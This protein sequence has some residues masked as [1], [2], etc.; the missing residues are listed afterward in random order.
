MGDTGLRIR[1]IQVKW[2]GFEVEIDQSVSWM[3]KPADPKP[4]CLNAQEA[5]AKV[6]FMLR[7]S[8]GKVESGSR[9]AN[10][11]ELLLLTSQRLLWFF[12]LNT[13]WNTNCVKHC[14]GLQW[15]GRE[16]DVVEAP[17]QDWQCRY[18]QF[19]GS[20]LYALVTMSRGPPVR[21]WAPGGRAL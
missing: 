9:P 17:W 2:V 5:K 14:N 20:A 1:S 3:G 13:C 21:S 16:P 10:H 19:D 4:V 15:A 7:W 8:D 11:W 6:A 18:S 12:G